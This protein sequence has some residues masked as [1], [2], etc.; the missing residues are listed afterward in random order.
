MAATR[1][2]HHSAS[3]EAIGVLNRVT[4]VDGEALPTALELAREEIAALDLACSRFRSDSELAA[5]NR[6][7]GR[8]VRVSPLLLEAL[9][10]ALAAA[11]ETDGLVDPTV[12]PAL[13]ALGYDR[14]F[15]VVVTS[16]ERPTFR[17]VPASGWRSVSI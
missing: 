16:P 17:L 1:V 12:G 3:F 8:T 14:D 2:R 5:V 10:V 9:K 7:R 4:V 6:A 13:R 15:D 11:A